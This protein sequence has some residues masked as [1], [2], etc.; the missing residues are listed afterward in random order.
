MTDSNINLCHNT[1]VSRKSQRDGYKEKGYWTRGVNGWRSTDM[2]AD[3]RT[4]GNRM[5]RSGRKV[6]RR[7]FTLAKVKRCKF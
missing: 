4:E 7:Y 2:R 3:Y 1:R 5:K 6:T